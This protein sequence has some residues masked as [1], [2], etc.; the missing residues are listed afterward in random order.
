MD[1]SSLIIIKIIIDGIARIIIPILV[2]IVVYLLGKKPV[3]KMFDTRLSNIEKQLREHS[4]G[5]SDKEQEFMD[6][7][8]N[9]VFSK[10]EMRW[11]W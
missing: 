7:T 9:E 2:P 5:Y 8:L 4:R 10:P 6:K 3:K 1:N 11:F